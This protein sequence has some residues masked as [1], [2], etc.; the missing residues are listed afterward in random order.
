MNTLSNLSKQDS[1][2][3]LS[4]SV[5]YK[6]SIR[7]NEKKRDPKLPRLKRSARRS[8]LRLRSWNDKYTY[9]FRVPRLPSIQ[10]ESNLKKSKNMKRLL[11][12]KP[13][14][15][16]KR[17]GFLLRIWT[18]LP[19]DKILKIRFVKRK[20]FW[21]PRKRKNLAKP[22]PKRV[23]R[24]ALWKTRSATRSLTSSKFLIGKIRHW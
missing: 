3:N 1:S 7:R 14:L 12:Q 6:R 22:S 20:L 15:L 23:M 8:V 17:L 13:K 9:F 11:K 21:Q 18:A 2:L 19:A 16:R 5:T 24:N 10:P 4:I